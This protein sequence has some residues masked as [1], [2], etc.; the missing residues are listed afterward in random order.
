MEFSEHSGENLLKM[1]VN[2]VDELLKI[3]GPSDVLLERDL[4]ECSKLGHKLI[5][6]DYFNGLEDAADD[7]F[8]SLSSYDGDVSGLTDKFNRWSRIYRDSMKVKS[9]D[10]RKFFSLISDN[11]EDLC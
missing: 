10:Y 1:I 11:I 6:H 3:Y 2:E 5:E 9:D 8:K 7:Y 4:T